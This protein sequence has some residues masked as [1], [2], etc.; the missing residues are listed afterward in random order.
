MNK[1]GSAFF[2]I[3]IGSFIYI[4]GVLFIPF[5]MDDIDTFRDNMDC[6]NSAISD[7]TKIA[8]LGSDI[9]IPYFIWFFISLLLGFVAG[10]LK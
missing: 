2:G 7:G 8:C 6:T 1:K 3:A 4:M 9:L 5:I 10:V